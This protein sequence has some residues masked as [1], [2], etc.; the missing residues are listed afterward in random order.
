MSRERGGRLDRLWGTWD[1][2]GHELGLDER[3]GIERSRVRLQRG[4]TIVVWIVVE[5]RLF[6]EPGIRVDLGLQSGP[7]IDRIDRLHG[8]RRFVQFD[9][10]FLELELR[11][12][13]VRGRL[14]VELCQPFRVQ[15]RVGR[16]R[17][18]WIAGLGHVA[19][20]RDGLGRLRDHSGGDHHPV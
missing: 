19:S 1:R 7:R 8:E 14:V 13:L 2:S 15:V 17:S 6:L 9:C 5:F 12:E 16:A 11:R 20:V 3:F 10:G 18:Q 4:F